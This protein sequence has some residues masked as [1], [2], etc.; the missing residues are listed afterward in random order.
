[1]LF[2]NCQPL[3][4]PCKAPLS[5]CSCDFATLLECHP[6]LHAGQAPSRSLLAPEG[7]ILAT[8]LG[9]PAWLCWLQVTATSNKTNT[10]HRVAL[11]AFTQGTKQVALYDTP[12]I[13][14]PR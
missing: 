9:E 11:G 12:G 14:S 2:Y 6:C 10:T 4:L 7:H 5:S 8:V 3:W 1:M 13:V